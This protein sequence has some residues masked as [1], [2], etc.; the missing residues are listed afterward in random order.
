MPLTATPFLIIF[1]ASQVSL[2]SNLG[3][4]GLGMVF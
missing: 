1:S 3:P 2:V 4:I